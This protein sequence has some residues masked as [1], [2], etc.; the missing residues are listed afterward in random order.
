MFPIC[1]LSIHL[2]LEMWVVFKYLPF[3]INLQRKYR[4]IIFS[5]LIFKILDTYVGVE[6]WKMYYIHFKYF[7][8]LYQFT[9]T[10]PIFILNKSV[11]RI[12]T[13]VSHW[14]PL[15]YRSLK[16][17]WDYRSLSFWFIFISLIING[18]WQVFCT[19]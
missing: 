12:P 9:E 11:M 1:V 16:H 5:N 8:S 18:F 14:C 17:R 3:L 2:S 4:S 19:C 13:T 7:Y 15:E 6:F 10:K